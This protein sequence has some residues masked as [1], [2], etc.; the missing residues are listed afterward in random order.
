M[1]SA[2]LPAPARLPS[3][4]PPPVDE[5]ARPFS[6]EL[7]GGAATEPAVDD[8]TLSA[9][10]NGPVPARRIHSPFVQPLPPRPA[11]GVTVA[12]PAG[13]P[14]GPSPRPATSPVRPSTPPPK[15]STP[16]PEPPMPSARLPAPARLPSPNPPPVDEIA[17]PF[18]SELAGGAATEPAV[19]DGTLSA[20]LNG[21]V[22][23]RRI[24]SPFVQ[25]LPPRPARGVTPAC[26]PPATPARTTPQ[27][28]RLATP[29]P[30]VTCASRQEQ[31]SE[32]PQVHALADPGHS[33][34][35]RE[36]RKSAQQSRD[37]TRTP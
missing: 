35:P 6:S 14:P 16:P 15:T 13:S 12:K 18:S 25:P 31:H 37:R 34:G 32:S 19:D 28:E 5:I 20:L 7:A 4:N 23:A 2:R 33:T 8:G 24:H 1:P 36:L 9:L 22:P 26:T 3:P 10:L 27:A 29:V 30:S 21:P 11:R 17:R